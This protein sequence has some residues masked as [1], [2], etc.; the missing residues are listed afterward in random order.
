VYPAGEGGGP[1]LWAV[2]GARE[3]RSMPDVRYLEALIGRLQA[4]YNIDPAHIH[5]EGLSNGGAMAF[6]LSCALSDRVA[7][8]AAV[9]AANFVPFEW[10][11]DRT[12]VAMIAFH[13]TDDRV[14][15]FNGGKTFVALDP[16]PPIPQWTGKWAR[17]NGCSPEPRESRIAT[18]VTRRDYAGCTNDASVVLYTIEGGGHTWPG[19]TPLPEWLLGRTTR[20]IDAT[21]LAWA[22]FRDHPLPR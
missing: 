17:R 2:R 4:S 15:P 9:A 8:V 14:T 21:Q 10:C 18:D 22:F 12:P 6:V 19:G 20:S 11:R 13:G 5:V 3:R 7:S 16:F 1:R